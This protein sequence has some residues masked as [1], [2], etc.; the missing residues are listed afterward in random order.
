MPETGTRGRGRPPSMPD[1]VREALVLDAATSLFARLGFHT[2]TMDAIA[3]RAAVRKPNLYRQF[4]S[5]DAAYAAVL[6]QACDRLE[7]FL[8]RAYASSAGLSE[9]ERAR[10]CVGAL[11]AFARDQPEAFALVFSAD[12]PRS[13]APARRV[14]ETLARIADSIADLLRGEFT[15]RGVDA[16]RAPDVIA[17]GIVG[18]CVF[19]ARRATVEPEWDGEAVADLLSAFTV[20]GLNGLPRRVLRDFG[21]A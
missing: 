10:L 1:N 17:E 2:T 11:F 16:D 20:G 5:K 18:M 4:A 6:E 3:A 7:Y 12:R 9:D 15:D 19:A 14:D 8:H 13:G 21:T